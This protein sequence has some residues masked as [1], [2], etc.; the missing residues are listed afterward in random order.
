MLAFNI[1]AAQHKIG[2]VDLEAIIKRMPE[3]V[4]AESILKQYQD[5]VQNE[6]GKLEEEYNKK[7]ESFM[8]CIPSLTPLPDSLK[9]VKRDD[10]FNYKTSKF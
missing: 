6:Y 8:K 5:S 3:T 7:M 1:A 10:Y 9:Q 2:S 4:K